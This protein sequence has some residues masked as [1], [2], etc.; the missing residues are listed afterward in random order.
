MRL[1]IFGA[2]GYGQ[3]VADIARQSGRYT[4]ICFLD[5]GKTGEGILGKCSDYLRFADEKTEMYPA[6]G[7]N[8]VRLQW[9]D[10]LAEAGIPVP[11]LV[12]TSAYVSPTAQIAEGTV[13]LPKALV[14]TNCQIERGCIVNCGCIVDHG[15]VLEEGVHICLGV[16]VKAENRI[17]AC[18]KV[19]AGEIVQNRTYPV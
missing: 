4:Q 14:N 7:N 5:D 12:H 18:T 9:L 11:T 19:E 1:I 3:T 2:G 15:C 10:R 13:I 16:I 8:T 6:F 17:S